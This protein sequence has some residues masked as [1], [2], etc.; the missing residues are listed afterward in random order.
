MIILYFCYC[1]INTDKR[2]FFSLLTQTAEFYHITRGRV[3]LDVFC[4]IF[5]Y[6]TM[7]LDYFYNKFIELSAGER[8]KYTSRLFMYKFHKK[9]NKKEDRKIF[10]NKNLFHVNFRSYISHNTWN[11]SV[12]SSLNSFLSWVVE[13][14]P[15][16]IVL[17][18]PIGQAGKS[19][20]VITI[21]YSAT[22]CLNMENSIK[23]MIT[24]KMK[25]AYIL[26]EAYIQQHNLFMRLFPGALNTVRITT[27]LHSNGYVEFL[28]AIIRIGYD[29][30]VD[31]FDAGGISALIDLK[32]GIVIRNGIFKNPFKSRDLENH[33]V[34]GF[35]IIGLHV[36]FWSDIIN[37]VKSAA[38]VIPTIRTVGWDVI[39]TETGPALLEGN[40]NWDKTH[41]E[42]CEN[43]GMK[44]KVL[45]LYNEE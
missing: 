40:D 25:E 24:N 35:P 27:F 12:P 31:N 19:V 9:F 6:E 42:C 10:Q 17:K 26:V 44:D 45:A 43:K 22:D 18:D 21:D 14:K 1:I 34:T 4:C 32:T 20:L 39:I 5:R 11:L 23:N 29:K 2:K 38:I 8:N 7:P 13:S 3:F 41:W 28:Y 37:M 33:P 16:K 36:P 15:E 30:P